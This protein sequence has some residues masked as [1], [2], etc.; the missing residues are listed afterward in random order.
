MSGG[1]ARGVL[2]QLAVSVLGAGAGLG[3][4]QVGSILCRG[5]SEL[6]RPGEGG[7]QR[8][9]EVEGGGHAPWSSTME[10]QVEEAME[11]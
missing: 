3:R 8:Q 6:P 9:K 1:F 7:P 4:A 11:T 2:R 5:L 10:G